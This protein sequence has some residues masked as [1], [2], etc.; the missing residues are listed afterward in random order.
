MLCR[1]L[2]PAKD[3]EHT[4]PFRSC[5]VVPGL[6][7][8]R[9]LRTTRGWQ[10][11]LFY[12]D[13]AL[14][15]F[16]TSLLVVGTLRTVFG[17]PTFWHNLLPANRSALACAFLA[18]VVWNLGNVLLMAGITPAGMAGFLPA[19]RCFRRTLAVDCRNPK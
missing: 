6:V 7:A 1:R 2:C 15:I 13:F 9:H 5:N 4:P 19:Q 18:G 17:L 8:S 10:Y 3:L 14:G 11:V 12:R 16:L